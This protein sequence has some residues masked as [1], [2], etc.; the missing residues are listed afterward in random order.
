MEEIEK[1]YALKVINEQLENRVV[2]PPIIMKE[3][4]RSTVALM[5]ADNTANLGGYTEWVWNIPSRELYP[6]HGA[7]GERQ[8]TPVR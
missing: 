5:V 6:H 4:T 1:E 7:K 3:E 8:W 2:I